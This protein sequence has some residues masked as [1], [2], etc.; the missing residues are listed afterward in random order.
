MGSAPVSE[1]VAFIVTVD[2]FDLYPAPAVILYFFCE[3][4][5]FGIVR[6]AVRLGEKESVCQVLFNWAEID[7][8]LKVCGGVDGSLEIKVPSAEKEKDCAVF[9]F[10]N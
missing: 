7:F 8:G 9:A 1:V 10:E 6:F 3:D 4:G 2:F 5:L